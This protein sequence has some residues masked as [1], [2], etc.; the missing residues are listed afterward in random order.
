MR[1]YD[2]S[3]IE[4]YRKDKMNTNK[5]NEIFKKI[6]KDFDMMDK[7]FDHPSRESDWLIDDWHFFKY[8]VFKLLREIYIEVNQL[9]YNHDELLF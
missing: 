1:K 8:D 2:L 9:P 4:K 5:I 6:S 3:E 7:L